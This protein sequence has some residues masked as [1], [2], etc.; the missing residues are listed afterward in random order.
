MLEG[1]MQTAVFEL[2]ALA[3]NL[4]VLTLYMVVTEGAGI[5]VHSISAGSAILQANMQ[6]H[7]MQLGATLASVPLL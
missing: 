2:C 4:V 5:D 3:A 6:P 1:S 7:G